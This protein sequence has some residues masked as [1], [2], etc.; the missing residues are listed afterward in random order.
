MQQ[1]VRCPN[2]GQSIRFIEEHQQWYCDSCGLYPFA[3][4]QPAPQF[5]PYYP[6]YPYYPPQ[7]SSDLGGKI[8]LILLLIFLV[9][10]FVGPLLFFLLTPPIDGDWDNTPHGTLNF[11]EE[12]GNYTGS[13]VFLDDRVVLEDVALVITDD[14]FGSDAT[15]EPI[16]HGG[17]ARVP[18]GITCTYTDVDGDGELDIDDTFTI[19][20]GEPGD[21]IRLRFRPTWGNIATATLR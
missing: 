7:K 4:S 11:T 1:G 10:M 8:I 16:F 15:L 14:S 20:N 13:L 21:T 6:P 18:G 2:C 3:Q 19:E 12:D 5:M 17:R 9:V